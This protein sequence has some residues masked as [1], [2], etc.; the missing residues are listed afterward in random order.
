MPSAMCVSPITF[1]NQTKTK[2]A[3]NIMTIKNKKMFY[4]SV[5]DISNMLGHYMFLVT[6][7]KEEYEKLADTVA[8]MLSV[9][10]LSAGGGPDDSSE[11]GKYMKR[12]RPFKKDDDIIDEA[13]NIINNSN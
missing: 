11:I 1:L 4:T 7:S 2:K 8:S 12:R 5:A 9:L 10:V 13:N 6:D 3:R